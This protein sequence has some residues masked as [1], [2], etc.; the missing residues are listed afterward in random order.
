MSSNSRL[1][2]FAKAAP[3]HMFVGIALSLV[4]M[5]AVQIFY[6]VSYTVKGVFNSDVMEYGVCILGAIVFQYMRFYFALAGADDFQK[7][8]NGIGFAGL[9][10]GILLTAAHSYEIYHI[11]DTLTKSEIQFLALMAFLQTIAWGGL[12]TELRIAL[13]LYDPSRQ[14]GEANDKLLGALVAEKYLATD[15]DIMKLLEASQSSPNGHK[16]PKGGN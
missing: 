4:V 13:N 3:T 5:G 1:A 11:V 15:G 8:K 6:H 2:T 10:F 14:N 7:G 9:F 16:Q 12:V